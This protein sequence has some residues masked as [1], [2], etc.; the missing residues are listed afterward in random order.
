MQNV[1]AA[2]ACG[3]NQD[4]SAL[5]CTSLCCSCSDYVSPSNDAYPALRAIQEE[6]NNRLNSG[7]CE[8]LVCPRVAC[9]EPTPNNCEARTCMSR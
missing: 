5:V 9:L 6:F 7:W 4:C 3:C 1:A 2:K 8:H